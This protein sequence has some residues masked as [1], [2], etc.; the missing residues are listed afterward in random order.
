[1]HWPAPFVYLGPRLE[2]VSAL[3]LACG[4]LFGCASSENKSSAI[5]GHDASGTA[6]VDAVQNADLSAHF[7]SQPPSQSGPVA[8]HP[9]EPLLFPGTDE[10]IVPPINHNNAERTASL[11]G[12][13]LVSNGIEMNFDDVNV[14]VVAKALLGD[15]LHL[16]FVIDPR[17]QAKITLASAAPVPRKDV[18]PVFESVLRMSNVAIVQDKNFVKIIPIA[19]AVGGFEPGELGFGVS[20][21]PL[22]YTSATTVA[23]MI[24]NFVSRQGAVKVD[25]SRNLLLVRGTTAERES[26][27]DVVNAF[28][29]EWLRNRSVGIY[30][31]KSTAP[32]TLIGELEP[33]FEAKE[34]GQ[35]DGVVSFQPVGRMN[36]VMA[37]TKSPKMLERVTEWV[38]R[39]DRSDSSGTTARVYRVKYGS[40]TQLAKVLNNIFVGN[41]AIDTATN[42]IAPGKG[43]ALSK[44]ESPQQG[45]N[46]GPGSS[47]STSGSTGSTNGSF[48]TIS[49]AFDAFSSNRKNSAQ[50]QGSIPVAPSGHST[51]SVFQN[52]RITADEATNSLI[53]YSNQEDYHVIERALLGIDRVQPQVDIDSVIAEVDLTDQ[54]QYGIQ[55]FLQ[56]G[57]FTSS[58]N[59]GQQSSTSTSTSSASSLLSLLPASS[60]YNFLLGALANPQ[61]IL[62]A[63]SSVTHVRVLSAPSVLAVDNQPAILQ[64]G[65]QVPISTGTATILSNSSTPIVNTIE[66]RDTGVILKVWPHVHPNGTI[67]LEVEQEISN[68]APNQTQTLTPTISQR[69][70]HSTISVAS[71][72][73][74]LLGGLISERDEVDRIGIPGL[75]QIKILGDLTSSVSTN[76]Q[77][78]ELIVFIKPSLIRNSMDAKRIT[79]EFR[80]RLSLMRPHAS[81]IQGGEVLKK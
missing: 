14:D 43:V 5:L 17:V 70:I 58:F 68:V 6:V 72:Q 32:E 30:P 38:Q 2:A 77:R 25:Q 80:D 42:Q 62:S 54:L 3:V 7:A 10:S 37:V 4:V 21:M 27:V 81:V 16:N 64:V 78:T 61:L 18:L 33:V 65:D 45:T 15:I 47:P 24:E 39:L 13:A 48:P 73:T 49:A 76:K 74:V 41:G 9:S 44:L 50:A 35:G 56:S 63:L 31:L 36:A 75:D 40:A 23:R 53:I 71:G 19:D 69:R 60:G 28:D 51:S 67:D 11:Q 20:V 66:M 55:H 1:V 46:A 22:R 8:D 12:A 57:N 79:Q 52:V 29:V 26:A 34:G 59:N